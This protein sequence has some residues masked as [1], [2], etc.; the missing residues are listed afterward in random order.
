[1]PAIRW[2][3]TFLVRRA[4]FRG[5][6]AQ[7]NHGSQ[8]LRVL[9]ALIS[10]PV[11]AFLLPVALALGQAKFMICLFKLSYHTGRVFALFGFNPIHEPYVTN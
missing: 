5:I 6:F 4:L 10:I 2:T 9:Q 3:R 11:Y 7:R 1:V 8:P